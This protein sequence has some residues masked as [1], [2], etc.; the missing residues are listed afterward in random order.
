MP[1]TS[2][3]IYQG[4]LRNQAEHLKSGQVILNDAPLDNNGKGEAFS[5]TDMVA[6]ALATCALTVMGI[7]AKQEGFDL[8]ETS[9]SVV[10]EMA[11]DPR[12]ISTVAISISIKA[13]CSEK[14]Q[15]ILE[16]VGRNCPVSKSLSSELKQEFQF[17]WTGA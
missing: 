1:L 3:V 16:G 11:S 15:K 14:M 8:E 10:K 7:R 13:N 2:K 4:N 5:P 9:A 12:R 17:N 6:T